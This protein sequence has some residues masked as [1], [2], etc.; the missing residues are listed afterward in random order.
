MT[1]VTW[2]DEARCELNCSALRYAKVAGADI[3]HRFV[4]NV[5]AAIAH[6]RVSPEQFRV[7]SGRARKVRVDR[8]PYAVIYWFEKESQSI[9]VVAIANLHRQPG[10]WRERLED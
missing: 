4:T 2:D 1:S 8:F 5:E 9:H 10:Y 3:A 6:A 7:F